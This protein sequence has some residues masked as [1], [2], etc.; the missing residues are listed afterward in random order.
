MKKVLFLF[1]ISVVLVGCASRKPT[2]IVKTQTER[3]IKRT[4]RQIPREIVVYKRDTIKKDTTIVVRGR[5]TELTVDIDKQG[6]KKA[7]CDT[8]GGNEIKEEIRENIK[9]TEKT[10]YIDK[11]TFFMYGMAFALFIMLV[12]FIKK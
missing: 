9:Q 10:E 8:S 5:V 3:K 4:I 6:I 1:V 2:K 12:L 11:K 7:T